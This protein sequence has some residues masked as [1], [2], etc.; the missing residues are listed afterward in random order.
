MVNRTC[1]VMLELPGPPKHGVVQAVVWPVAG[2]IPLPPLESCCHE[3]PV[4]ADDAVEL[5]AFSASV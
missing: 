3:Y 1:R 5:L 2:L 4:I